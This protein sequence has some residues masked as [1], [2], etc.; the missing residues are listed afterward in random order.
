MVIWLFGLVIRASW[1][2]VGESASASCDYN[3]IEDFRPGA[4]SP[5]FY[6]LIALN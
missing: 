2:H 5:S 6:L 3:N 1:A 4:Y